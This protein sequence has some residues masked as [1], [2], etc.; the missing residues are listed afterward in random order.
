MYR[1][2][3]F[4]RSGLHVAVPRRL[5]SN[6]PRTPLSFCTCVYVCVCVSMCACLFSLSN[7]LLLSY[8]S[9]SISLSLSPSLRPHPSQPETIIFTA[10][11]TR[12][13]NFLAEPANHCV[14]WRGVLAVCGGDLQLGRVPVTRSYGAGGRPRH[15]RRVR[16]HR[17]PAPPALSGLTRG[18]E[19]RPYPARAERRKRTRFLLI[20]VPIAFLRLLPSV[21]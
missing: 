3:N 9:F 7:S 5:S 12:C 11:Q 19:R 16:S 15:H 10:R 2:A 13:C 6:L 20:Y 14:C 17:V 1:C 21:T 18:G 8:H 4:C